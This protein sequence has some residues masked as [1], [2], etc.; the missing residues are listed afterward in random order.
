M[1]TTPLHI[2]F[3]RALV[4]I[5]PNQWYNLV[6]KITHIGLSNERD[7]F[8]WNL[9]RN[10]QFTVHSMYLYLM[11]HNPHFTHKI[12]WSL[13]VPLKIK[14]F[15]WYLQHVVILT[16]DNLVKHNW[17]DSQKCCFCNCNE[18]IKHLFSKTIWRVV[19]IA[20]GLTTPTSIIHMLGN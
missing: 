13:K 15:L 9:C 14:I 5:N 18:T 2:S 19:N 11:N 8:S 17:K 1:R 7:T 20:T 4:G 6:A 3:R 12:I 16:K 10:C